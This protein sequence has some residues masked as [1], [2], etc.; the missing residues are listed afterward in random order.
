MYERTSVVDATN[1]EQLGPYRVQRKLGRGGMGTVY[2]AVNLESGEPAA[3][4]ILSFALADDEGF[5][6]RF[7]NEIETLRKLNHPGIVRLLGYGEQYGH[8]F[9]AMELI[10]GVSLEEE[11]RQ[12]RRFSW[13]ETTH[14]G[15]EICR[16][17]RHAHDRGIVHRD[18]KP[19]NLL[20]SED[21]RVKLADFGIARL[22]GH[23]PMT[24]VGSVL[25]TAEYMAPEQAEGRPVDRRADL[26]SLGCVLYS[27]LAGRPPFQAPSLAALLEKQRTAQ[28]TPLRDLIADTP[29]E[30]DAIVGQLLAKEPEQ[31][32]GNATVVQR[33]LEG[34]L[35]A[36]SI[37]PESAPRGE[38]P[39]D[40]PGG[41]GSEPTLNDVT[42][43]PQ[44]VILSGAEDPAE[45]RP[46]DALAETMLTEALAARMPQS[47]ADGSPSQLAVTQA[48]ANVDAAEPPVAAESTT[49][50]LGPPTGLTA[51]RFVHVREDE[52]GRLPLDEPEHRALISL[53]TFVLV[54]GLLTVAALVW[55]FLQPP[56]ADGLY[57]AVAHRAADKTNES[58]VDAE[59]YIMQFLQ[60]FPKDPRAEELRGYQRDIEVYQLERKFERRAAGLLRSESLPPVE[61]VYLEAI[62]QSRFEPER[63]V[64]SLEAL[65]ALYDHRAESTGPTGRCLDLARRQLKRIQERLAAQAQQELTLIQT[66]LDLADQLQKT[67]PAR[68]RSLRQAVVTLYG[69]KPWAAPAV[70]R[71][72]T[73]LR[74]AAKPTA[75]KPAAAPAVTK[76]AAEK[77]ATGNHP[78]SEKRP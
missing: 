69:D 45:D 42:A 62:Q 60:L 75:A 22:F 33:R 25:G 19:G 46:I 47:L 8:L 76:A 13:R 34:L 39:S 50:P 30:L 57:A 29:A 55:W 17:L 4:K 54:G 59:P 72:Q 68:S 37:G 27:L 10:G 36:L 24:L 71:A 26:Y 66:R 14:M 2:E 43:P 53:H 6:E 3:V 64:L 51:N 11:L 7:G 28:P 65:I 21:G 41:A 18:L 35:A 32:L 23:S 31:R 63:A 5:R 40:S 74:P 1:I 16:A 58:L 52:L 20:L 12:G 44:A 70:K 61:R 56:T 48:T 77:S 78:P 9:Y 73:G 49:P 38:A 15:I 67:D